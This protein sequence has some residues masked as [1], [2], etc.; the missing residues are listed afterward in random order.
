MLLVFFMD[1]CNT[2]INFALRIHE[3][4]IINFRRIDSQSLKMNKKYCWVFHC[5]NKCI[6]KN[7]ISNITST[8]LKVFRVSLRELKITPPPRFSLFCGKDRFAFKSFTTAYSKIN[9]KAT[10]ILNLDVFH[11]LLQDKKYI[12]YI[13]A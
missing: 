9:F 10:Y 3:F 2:N 13:N 12:I 6:F 4:W 5:A 1:K 7:T 8:Q 11:E